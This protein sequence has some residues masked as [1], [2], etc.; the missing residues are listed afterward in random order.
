[1]WS[2]SNCTYINAKDG[3]KTDDADLIE[4]KSS[5]KSLSPL[6]FLPCEFTKF[7]AKVR[8]SAWKL[9]AVGNYVPEY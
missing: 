7:L 5:I 9:L 2:H 8:I 1:M 6:P 4:D 3:L